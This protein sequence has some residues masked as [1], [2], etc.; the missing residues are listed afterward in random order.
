MKWM[1]IIF[2][3][4]CILIYIWVI[5]DIYKRFKK[6]NKLLSPIWLLLIFLLPVLG[7]LIYLTTR[8]KD[9]NNKGL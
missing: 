1:V 6:G 8:E 9:F 4:L 2:I 7:P 3:L 5:V